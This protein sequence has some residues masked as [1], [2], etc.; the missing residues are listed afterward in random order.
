MPGKFEPLNEGPLFQLNGI[1][2]PLFQK[3]IEPLFQP[4]FH[5][6]VL[7]PHDGLPLPQPMFGPPPHAGPP[8]PILKPLP[9]PLPQD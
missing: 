8:L 2:G 1:L 3:G 4:L 6:I 9:G 5:G 7:P